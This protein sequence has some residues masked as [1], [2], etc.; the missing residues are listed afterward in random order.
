[1]QRHKVCNGEMLCS[2]STGLPV[3]WTEDVRGISPILQAT[4]ID[5]AHSL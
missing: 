4:E 3:V 1:M 5:Q 2:K